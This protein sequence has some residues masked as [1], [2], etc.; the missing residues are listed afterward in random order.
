MQSHCL[1]VS[2]PNNFSVHQPIPIQFVGRGEVS[3]Y[4]IL[5]SLPAVCWVV[6]W[7][8]GNLDQVRNRS[9]FYT[10]SRRRAA[11]SQLVA[12]RQP[13]LVV[14]R[15]SAAVARAGCAPSAERKR[16][17][18]RTELQ[19]L[20]ARLGREDGVCVSHGCQNAGAER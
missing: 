17:S 1:G 4:C 8:A 3:K 2:V 16:V 10:K 13:Q 14:K 11:G 6:K 5:P 20:S 7:G 18:G 19:L 9:T 15:T 12:S